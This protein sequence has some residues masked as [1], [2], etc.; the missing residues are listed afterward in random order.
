MPKNE[1]PRLP[2][3]N[4]VRPS[5]SSGSFVGPGVGSLFPNTD[6]LLP[7]PTYH[8]PPFPGMPLVGCPLPCFFP[9]SGTVPVPNNMTSHYLPPPLLPLPGT[10]FFPPHLPMSFQ[11]G[12]GS[13]GFYFGEYLGSTD[14]GS[15][16]KREDPSSEKKEKKERMKTP[17]G[18]RF[19]TETSFT[20]FY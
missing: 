14:V 6:G 15:K 9:T 13:E 20:L 4:T 8:G 3:A 5:L 1:N 16:K 10:E 12:Y 11:T 7:T 19:F 18:Y 17:P 2:P